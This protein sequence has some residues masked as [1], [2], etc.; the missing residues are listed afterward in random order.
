M[1]EYL[2]FKGVLMCGIHLC[3]ESGQACRPAVLS[4]AHEQVADPMVRSHR[5]RLVV[6][7]V[8]SILRL[9]N[10]QDDTHAGSACRRPK[11][12]RRPCGV[13][14]LRRV[15]EVNFYITHPAMKK[16]H[17]I[18]IKTKPDPAAAS[19]ASAPAPASSGSG[20]T[21]VN[22]R[23]YYIEAPSKDEG[24]RWLTALQQANID[25]QILNAPS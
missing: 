10:T 6:L 1:N 22:T 2:T 23:T 8:R 21:C 25:S 19:N 11:D 20:S 13:V 18:E 17:L 7:Q 12:K 24:I 4:A 16:S 5:D 3:R 15:S 14:P 9:S